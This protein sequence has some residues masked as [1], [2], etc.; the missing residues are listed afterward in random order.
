M[1]RRR[2]SKAP[3]RSCCRP[4]RRPATIRSKRCEMMNRI[5]EAVE[6]DMH[7]NGIIHAQRTEP[8]IDRRGH[9]HLVGQA[10]R[11]DAPAAGDRLLHVVRLHGPARLARASVG[12]GHRP[13]P[14]PPDGAA[15]L[16]G[17]GAA[18]RRQ[19]G[20]AQCLEM[21][22]RA[23]EIAVSRGICQARRPDHRDGG[24]PLRDVGRHQH[25]A[26]RLHRAGR[27]QRGLASRWPR[28][29]ARTASSPGNRRIPERSRAAD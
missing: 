4:N 5:A 3:T 21:V 25:A 6:Q 24:R 11:R 27:P 15:A 7:F 13:L 22:N 17:L 10:D 18:L 28:L 2:C 8:E 26:D 29:R 12:A 14:G 20:R 16:G 23:S 1:S 9:D 19:R